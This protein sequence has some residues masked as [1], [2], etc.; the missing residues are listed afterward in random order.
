MGRHLWLS[1]ILVLETADIGHV[2]HIEVCET[3]ELTMHVH[4]N[5]TLVQVSSRSTSGAR[6][7]SPQLTFF[8]QVSSLSAQVGV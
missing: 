4:V 3:A 6:S 7:R 1:C 2:G 8:V 5:Y